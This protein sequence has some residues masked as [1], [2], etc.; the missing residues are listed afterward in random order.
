MCIRDRSDAVNAYFS[1]AEGNFTFVNT[2]SFNAMGV[3]TLNIETKVRGVYTINPIEVAGFNGTLM[4]EDR[5]TGKTVA[6]D[7][8]FSFETAGGTNRFYIHFTSGNTSA[9]SKSVDVFTTNNEVNVNFATV[10]L[11]NATINVY[12]TAGQVVKTVNA[13]GNTSVSF[14]LSL[15]HI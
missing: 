4:I 11:A 15:I 6:F 14:D 7:K 9:I 1:N 2:P 3:A 10:E 5:R 8:P 13:N 12:N